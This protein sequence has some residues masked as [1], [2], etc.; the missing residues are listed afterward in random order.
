MFSRFGIAALVGGIAL[1]YFGF[2][3]KKL[4][5]AAS[6]EPEVISLQKLIERGPEGNPNIL[7]TEFAPCEN[8]VYESRGEHWTKVW[9][10][11]VPASGSV[12]QLFGKPA[13]KVQ[14]L[15]VSTK[16]RNETELGERFDKP[17][18]QALVTNRIASLK[19]KEKELLA[20]QY[21]GTDFEKCL[22]IQE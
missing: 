11:V 1:L 2:Q 13:T 22:I 19:G 5:D 18:L 15:I 4:S 6:D 12:A 10:P 3:E 8:I 7:L 14:A 17:Q 21:P 16:A 9:V 20:S